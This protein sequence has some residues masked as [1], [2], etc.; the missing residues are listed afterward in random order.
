MKL[1]D[2]LRVTNVLVKSACYVRDYVICNFFALYRTLR[3]IFIKEEKDVLFVVRTESLYT[4]HIN[5]SFRKDGYTF[6][7]KVFK[8]RNTRILY[9]LVP[10]RDYV[11][12]VLFI[13]HIQ[14]EL[15]LLRKR[16]SLCS[17][18]K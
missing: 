18:T 16:I 3:L 6:S 15:Y 13:R 12:L 10:W 5:F 8:Q 1:P 7:A 2:I 11:N 14:L 4:M 9:I 17:Y